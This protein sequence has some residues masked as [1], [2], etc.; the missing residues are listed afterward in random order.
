M[1]IYK[2]A[3]KRDCAY[4]TS[5]DLR[6]CT[7]QRRAPRSPL[8]HLWLAS[9]GL[10]KV[11][12]KSCAFTYWFIPHCEEKSLLKHLGI[13]NISLILSHFSCPSFLCCQI[14]ALE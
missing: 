4:L 10:L 7:Q 5:P 14:L 13:Y 3:K 8:A 6:M 11:L 1:Y 9:T 2:Q 12:I